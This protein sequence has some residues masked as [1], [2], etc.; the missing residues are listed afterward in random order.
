ME[1]LLNDKYIFIKEIGKGAYGTVG[2]YKDKETN[3][4]VAI[5]RVP[6]AEGGTIP[7]FLQRETCILSVLDHPNIIKLLNIINYDGSYYLV[8][9][10]IPHNLYDLLY[11]NKEKLSMIQIKEILYQTLKAVDFIH[12]SS[13]LHLDLKPGN[14]LVDDNNNVKVCDFGLSSFY[15]IP[16]RK[17]NLH[18][19][20]YPYRA[21][22]IFLGDE[23]YCTPVDVWS[24]GC[25]LFEAVNG[26]PLF[27]KNNKEDDDKEE[28]DLIEEEVFKVI[29]EIMGTP[30]NE[31][32]FG[33]TFLKNHS[34]YC[35]EKVKGKG[36]EAVN[37]RLDKKGM[38]LLKKMVVM[39]PEMRIHADEAMKHVRIYIFN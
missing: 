7:Q 32:W 33:V 39:N 10:Y 29:T 13:I 38:D 25:I 11:E 4:E 5:K 23:E 6:L 37:K 35:E 34:K 3:K 30:T 24:M 31:N 26:F 27:Y 15:Y 20:T 2:K 19:Q 14:I 22:E 1:P 17:H 28:I 12:R 8:F 9:D 18:V 21:P 16:Q 36:L